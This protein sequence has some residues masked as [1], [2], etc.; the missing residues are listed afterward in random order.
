MRRLCGNIAQKYPISRK[1]NVLM[2]LMGCPIWYGLFYDA[3]NISTALIVFGG[4]F[5]PFLE[6]SFQW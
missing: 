2:R 1:D 4:L 5:L 6:D 3:A